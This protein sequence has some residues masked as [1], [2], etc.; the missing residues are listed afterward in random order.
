MDLQNLIKY[1][2]TTILKKLKVIIKPHFKLKLGPG[3]PR[4]SCA[5]MVTKETYDGFVSIAAELAGWP[6]L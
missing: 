1:P 5:H 3:T 6:P 2:L 4:H